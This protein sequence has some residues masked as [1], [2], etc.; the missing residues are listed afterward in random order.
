MPAAAGS[1]GDLGP[2]TRPAVLVPPGCTEP[3]LTLTRVPTSTPRDA[4]FLDCWVRGV[5]TAVSNERVTLETPC[6]DPCV[7][8]VG[9]QAPMGPAELAVQHSRIFWSQGLPPCPETL[10]LRPRKFRSGPSAQERAE[11]DI[12]G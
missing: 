2:A 8:T 6:F 9:S 4:D 3:G 10:L 7:P 12:W 5:W 1:R 11:G